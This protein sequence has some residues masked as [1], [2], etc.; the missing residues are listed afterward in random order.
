MLPSVVPGGFFLITHT[1]TGQLVATAV[2][3]RAQTSWYPDAGVLGWVAAPPSTPARAWAGRCARQPVARLIGAGYRCIYL[4][5]RRLA[6]AGPQHYLRLGFEPV[7]VRSRHGGAL[8]GRVR[9]T[10]LAV[11]AR[12]VANGHSAATATG[13]AI[14]I[15]CARQ[16][17]RVGEA[18]P[19]PVD[20]SKRTGGQGCQEPCLV[21]TC[22]RLTD[23]RI[24]RT[25]RR[26]DLHGVARGAAQH[27]ASPGGARRLPAAPLPTRPR[28]SPPTWH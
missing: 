4:L 17:A 19:G 21:R 18:T 15:H 1:A 27:P 25:Q 12:P 16:V 14:T 26:A 5:Y 20:A 2:A 28:T 24:G 6:P 22:A 10:Q 23:E 13:G 3:K 11:H 7:P 8:E 9:A